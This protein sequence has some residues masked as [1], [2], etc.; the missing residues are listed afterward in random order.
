LL[1]QYS[2]ELDLP[3]KGPMNDLEV[4]SF[5][6]LVISSNVHPGQQRYW[7]TQQQQ[8]QQG[9][10]RMDMPPGYWELGDSAFAGEEKP[11]H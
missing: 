10:G 3:L 4:P 1:L 5:M 6:G 8:Q 9:P 2:I 7:N 11:S